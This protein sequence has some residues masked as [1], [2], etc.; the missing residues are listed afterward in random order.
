[1]FFRIRAAL[2]IALLAVLVT[3]IAALAKGGFSFISVT[4]GDLKD[5]LRLTD[6]DLTNDFFAFADFSQARTSVPKDPGTGY[7]ITRYYIDGTRETAF[8]R[9]HYYP[10]AG[11]VYYDGIVNG[12]SEYDGEWYTA[13][14][15]IK[16]TF[17]S[18]LPGKAKA[19]EPAV[20]QPVPAPQKA[21]A[22]ISDMRSQTLVLIAVTA[23]FAVI[24]LLVFWLRKPVTR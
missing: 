24:L 16:K 14:T 17:E 2:G 20:Q 11:L 1:M 22:T 6:P 15:V 21:Q 23:G 3:S 13:Q 5:E 4:G 19:I 18:A 8:D 12:S 10:D 7:E 9:L